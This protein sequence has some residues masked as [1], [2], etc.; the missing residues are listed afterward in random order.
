MSYEKIALII[1]LLSAMLVFT[2][3][4]ISLTLSAIRDHI[5][6]KEKRKAQ[7]KKTVRFL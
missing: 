2:G 7:G 3:L 6:W 5:E 4:G 1:F